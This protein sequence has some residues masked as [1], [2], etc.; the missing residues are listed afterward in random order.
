ML[1][2]E[3]IHFI[4]KNRSLIVCEDN[5]VYLLPCIQLRNWISN[6]TI[7]FPNQTI[8]SDNYTIIPHG[9]VTL[10]FFYDAT[11]L[12]SLLFGPTTKPKTVGNIANR[13][14]V[15]L[16]IEF[17]PA[18]FFPLIGIQQSE[19]IDKVV[20]FSII[21]TSLDLEI[22]KI[23][24]ESLSIDKLILKLE[25]LL[26]SNIKI[27]YSYEFILA[28][29][30]IIQN[31]GNISSQEI[32]KKVFYSSRHLNRLFNQ[33]LGLSMKSFSRLV[34]INKSIKLLNN[35]KTS[36]MS[37]CNELG[38]YDIP[39]FIKDFKIVCGITPQKYRANMSDFYSEIAKF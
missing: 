26:I 38:F 5:F 29:Q 28:I 36:L 13:C 17:Q 15:I 4:N 7:S 27:E 19:L 18:G 23:F 16:I 20:P 1:K 39:H 10:V 12:H 6:F 37:I 2:K 35:N 30:L 34:R 22:K 9:S 14:D 11:G 33:Y 8:I 21:N 31:S 25:E 3:S 32:S 24:N